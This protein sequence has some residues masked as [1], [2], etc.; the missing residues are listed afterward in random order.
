MAILLCSRNDTVRNKWFEALHPDWQV[1]QADS[2][3][4]MYS[5]LKQFR[6]EM[7]LI[8]RNMIDMGQ[9]KE[10]AGRVA[11]VKLFV[12]AD[13]PDDQEG[14]GCLYLGCV[15]Y[16]NTYIAK[17]RL[18]AAVEAVE[19]GLAWVGSSLMQYLIKSVPAGAGKVG[20]GGED[21]Q[22]NQALSGLSKREY[23]IA[24]LIADGLSNGEIAAQLEITERTV[25]SHLSSIYSKTQTKG[26]LNLALLMRKGTG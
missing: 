20:E 9:L 11:G 7:I 6:V 16:A 24:V 13:R 5:V 3:E 19:S 22:D 12:L 21:I 25:K 8:H 23:Q 14:A 18:R 2:V 4:Q 17:P 15:G 10:L 1:H 26:R